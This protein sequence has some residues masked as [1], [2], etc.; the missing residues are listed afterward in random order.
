MYGNFEGSFLEWCIVWV[1][2]KT[3]PVLCFTDFKF[4]FNVAG[5]IGWS[6]HSI[7]QSSYTTTMLYTLDMWYDMIWIDMIWYNIICMIFTLISRIYTYYL[8]TFTNI[9][10]IQN[11]TKTRHT[12]LPR[13]SPLLQ[14]CHT[15]RR[16]D[17][18]RLGRCSG[19]SWQREGLPPGGAG[20]G[21]FFAAANR[22]AV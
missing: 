10:L 15:Q 4:C 3:T 18:K 14:Q 13:P 21:G 12:S 5:F 1:G 16:L 17:E 20:V 6:W 2:N 9:L 19:M 22:V 11:A 7:L 8:L